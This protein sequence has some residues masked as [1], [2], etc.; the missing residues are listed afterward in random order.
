M[1]KYE[2]GH[3]LEMSEEEIQELKNTRISAMKLE[4]EEDLKLSE[5]KVSVIT[6]ELEPQDLVVNDMGTY[7]E[8]II[9]SDKEQIEE[10]FEDVMIS[11][12]RFNRVVVER[13]K[14]GESMQDIIDEISNDV[15]F[16]F[17]TALKPGT[18]Y[19]RNRHKITELFE[20]CF[21][22]TKKVEALEARIEVLEGFHI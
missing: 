17:E 16:Y 3:Y 14:N 21:R 10:S 7:W 20:I 1:I 2:N 4:N 9:C 5:I 22:L 8:I 15:D 13:K 6:Q 12:W 11:L 19:M 18:L